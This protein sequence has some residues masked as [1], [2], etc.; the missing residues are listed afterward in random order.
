MTI[1]RQDNFFNFKFPSEDK[2]IFFH[3]KDEVEEWKTKVGL[4]KELVGANMEQDPDFAHGFRGM[5]PLEDDLRNFTF[6]WRSWPVFVRRYKDSSGVTKDTVWS[7]PT[8]RLQKPE[9]M[10]AEAFQAHFKNAQVYVNANFDAIKCAI[11]ESCEEKQS[12]K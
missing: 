8:F 6:L 1:E 2:G 10:D 5:I 9:E 7:L 12:K 4:L 3:G 11:F